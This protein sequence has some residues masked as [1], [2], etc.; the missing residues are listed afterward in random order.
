[1]RQWRHLR[2]LK[3]AGRGNDPDRK[4]EETRPGELAV[5]CPACPHPDIN[6]PAGWENASPDVRALYIL[7]IAVDACFR[8]KRLAKS[9]EA[10]DPGLGNGWAY[11]SDVK[12]F[13][14]Y[15]KNVTDQKDVSYRQ[16]LQAVDLLTPLQMSSC[17]GFAAMDMAN[18]KY[19]KG[20]ASTGIALAVCA[21][22]EFVMRNG[23][24]DLQK[25]ER[26]A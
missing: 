3:R 18:T 12:P 24:C 4:V 25:G 21:R 11:Y 17:S 1:M 26:C 5:L 10:K 6:L 23:V 16:D 9:S 2:M 13:Y 8:L 22:H 19:S 14:E 20:Y 7:F 15:L